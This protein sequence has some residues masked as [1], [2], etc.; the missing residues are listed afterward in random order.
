MQNMLRAYKA[1][2][3]Q[4]LAHPTR[5]AIVEILRD[6]ELSTRAIQERLGVEQANLS[7]HLAILR[8]RQIVQNRKEGNQVFYSLGNPVLG[9]VLDIMRRYFQAHLSEAVQM[10]GGIESEGSAR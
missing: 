4:A 5:V 2:V 9:E 3:F 10:L 6:G 8:S 1:S 7:Q